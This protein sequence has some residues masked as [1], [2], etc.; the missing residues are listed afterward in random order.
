ME[1]INKELTHETLCNFLN[2]L[3]GVDSQGNPKSLVSY[4]MFGLNEPEDSVNKK[5]IY[6]INRAELY[7]SISKQHPD[8]IKMDIK[9]FA[10]D[11]TELR[12]L[13]ARLKKFD[14][15]EVENPNEDYVFHFT[16]MGNDI[17]INENGSE[18]VTFGHFM[19]PAMSYLTRE[20]PTSVAEDKLVD[21]ELLGGNVVRMLIPLKLVA[22]QVSSDFDRNSIKAEV[23]REIMDTEYRDN[24][25]PESFRGDI[26]N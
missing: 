17:A 26:S 21:N 11:D 9:F 12:L 4:Q 6:N 14:R 15:I 19:N 13:W 5:A 2:N 10:Y 8:Y 22:F 24:Y 3:S 23:Q 20:T 7:F 16:V 25:T 18:T 1:S